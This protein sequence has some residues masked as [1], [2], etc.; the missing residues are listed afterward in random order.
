MKIV[1]KKQK[2]Q[3]K[4]AFIWAKKNWFDISI[5][6]RTHSQTECTMAAFIS[7]CCGLDFGRKLHP[8][9]MET[10]NHRV[11]NS[12]ERLVDYLQ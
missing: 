1:K 10:V 12:N 2:K 7:A 9:Y 4:L 8:P 5:V 6:S 3:G 11:L